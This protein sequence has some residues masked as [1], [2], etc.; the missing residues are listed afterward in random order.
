MKFFRNIIERFTGKPVDWEELEESLIR[1]DIG[2]PMA[3]RILEAL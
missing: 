2:L 3:M 1:S